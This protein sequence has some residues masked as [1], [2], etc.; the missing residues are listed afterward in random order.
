MKN[1]IRTTAAVAAFCFFAG[2]AIAEPP[3]TSPRDQK[4]AAGAQDSF[5]LVPPKK[6]SVNIKDANAR[7]MYAYML[8][9]GYTYETSPAL[10]YVRIMDKMGVGVDEHLKE[11]MKESRKAS[12]DVT[13]QPFKVDGLKYSYAAKKYTYGKTS[14][15]YLCYVDPGKDEQTFLIFVLSSDYKNCGK[16][17][18]EFRTVLKSFVWGGTSGQ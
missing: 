11:D 16:Y 4:D 13:F 12:P 6:W 3:A 14:C 15:D 17:S 10:I 18:E 9:D 1:F 2:L 7:G 8:M 5:S